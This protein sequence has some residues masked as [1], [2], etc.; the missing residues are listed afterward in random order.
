MIIVVRPARRGACIPLFETTC[1]Q[2]S[3]PY[4][5]VCNSLLLSQK[6]VE[7]GAGNV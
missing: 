7:R 3:P 6:A 4:K 1:T 2:A 5:A